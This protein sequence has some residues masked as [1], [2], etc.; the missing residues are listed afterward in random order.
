MNPK[1]R[2]DT[3]A[4]E[5][6]MRRIEK[7]AGGKFLPII[8]PDKG[9]YLAETVRDS[10]VRRVLEVGTLVGYSAIL[11][12]S[13]LPGGGEVVTIEI[14][15]AVAK[16]AARNIK[17]AGLEDKVQVVVGDALEVIPTLRGPFDMAFLDAAKDEYLEYLKLA[18][19]KLAPRAVVF[20]DNVKIF[21]AQMTDFLD[22][23]RKGS[24]YSSRFI[25]VG[26]DGVEISRRL[27]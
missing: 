9:S 12:A 4:A 23:V 8:G 18:E 1:T 22:Y 13:N 5:A 14:N 7:Q 21:A 27:K 17:E 6:V 3:D 26:F 10:S 15:P 24:G 16:V 20:S 25:D 11:I 19:P 2:M